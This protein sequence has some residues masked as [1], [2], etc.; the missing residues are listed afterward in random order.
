MSDPIAVIRYVAGQVDDVA[1]TGDL[2]RMEQM[3]DTCWWVCICRGESGEKR[4]AFNLVWD[5]KQK[6]IVAVLWEDTI[7]CT[8]DSA[9]NADATP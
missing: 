2:F 4:T 1:I 3:S 7:G 8:D 5:R 9:G 6:R